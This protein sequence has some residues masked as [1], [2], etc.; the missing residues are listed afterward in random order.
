M[1][2][3]SC[4]AVRVNERRSTTGFRDKKKGKYRYP[5]DE[6][7]RSETFPA[8]GQSSD[9]LLTGRGQTQRGGRGQRQS[10][11]EKQ[12][13]SE[14]TK[15]KPK[16]CFASTKKAFHYYSLFFVGQDQAWVQDIVLWFPSAVP[17]NT[18]TFR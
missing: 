7:P 5:Q 15:R 17:A 12:T 4:L 10:D 18:N 8:I 14:R 9:L 3:K 6:P 11:K 2:L 1:P 13:V 16:K